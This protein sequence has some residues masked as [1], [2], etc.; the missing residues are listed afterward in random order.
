MNKLWDKQINENSKKNF[1]DSRKPM[2][3]V[4]DKMKQEKNDVHVKM[5]FMKVRCTMYI[6][7]S[8]CSES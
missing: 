5:L 4:C 7:V 1:W 3:K 6:D 8:L 2:Q